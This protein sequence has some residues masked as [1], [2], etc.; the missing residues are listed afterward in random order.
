MEQLVKAVYGNIVSYEE[1]NCVGVSTVT[2]AHASS[3]SYAELLQS[4]R[5]WRRNDFKTRNLQF[6]FEASFHPTSPRP[7][8]H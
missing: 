6:L 5:S 3:S 8:L 2:I 4:A 7:P 1:V